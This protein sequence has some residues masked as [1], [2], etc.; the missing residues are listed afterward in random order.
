MKTN[1]SIGYCQIKGRQPE[2]PEDEIALAGE[3]LTFYE[4]LLPKNSKKYKS[5]FYI[6]I[7]IILILIQCNLVPR[8]HSVGRGRS[9]YETTSNDDLNI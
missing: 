9:G 7:Q 8:S 5:L 6:I 3:F 4:E 2:S 1:N